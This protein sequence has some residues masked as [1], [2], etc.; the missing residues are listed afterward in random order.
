VARIL[1]IT[2]KTLYRMLQD[3]RVPEPGRNQANNFRVWI[4]QQ[5]EAIRQELG[6]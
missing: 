2:K 1:G 5:V 3:G 6:R 4:P